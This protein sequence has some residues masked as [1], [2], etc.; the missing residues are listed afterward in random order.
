MTVLYT[1]RSDWSLF[2]CYFQL[3]NG[4]NL[5]S[6]A[7]RKKF[8]C[9]RLGCQLGSSKSAI[10][11]KD[12]NAQEW[13]EQFPEAV[14]AIHMEHYTDDHTGNADTVEKGGK[15][16]NEVIKIHMAGGFKI[17]K[18]VSNSTEFLKLIPEELRATGSNFDN[19]AELPVERVLGLWWDAK[20]DVFT[21]K[22]NF[23]KVD[24]TILDGSRIPTKRQMASLVMSLYDPL[25]FVA[26]FKV[27]GMMLLQEAWK[28]K[29]SWDDKIPESLYQ[30]SV[31][32]VEELKTIVTTQIPRCYSHGF[33]TAKNVQ[34]HIF[35]DA[36]EKAF[37]AVSYLR[38]ET[39]TQVE[40]SIMDGKVRVAPLKKLTVPRLELQAALMGS[41][42][43]ETIKNSLDLKIDNVQFWSNSK[44]VLCWLRAKKINVK[45]FVAFQIG[46][47]LETNE[48]FCWRWIPTA[49]VADDATRENKPSDFSE[50][51]RWFNGP[52]FL[53][54]P[55]EN[56]PQENRKETE[57]GVTEADL[58]LCHVI[59]TIIIAEESLLPDISRFLSWTRLIRATVMKTKLAKVWQQKVIPGTHV[60]LPSEPGTR[61]QVTADEMKQAE[62]LWWRMVQV[63]SFSSEIRSIQKEKPLDRESRLRQLSP[64]L[65]EEGFPR[66]K[67]RI[68]A[69]LDLPV[70][71]KRPIILNPNHS[72]TKLL[73]DHCH[74]EGAHQGQARVMN[75]LRQKF[76]ILDIR[77]AVRASWTRCQECKNK[78]AQPI[79]PEMGALPSSRVTIR[80]LVKPELTTLV[81]WK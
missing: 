59:A 17:D 57:E 47:I 41:R 44:T 70:E 81:P 3:E 78:R 38:V 25:G 53:K 16:A 19:K 60:P 67:G 52:A 13:N 61:P 42:M 8:P 51:S 79:L 73:I 15:L 74:R 9:A 64:L 34:L 46:E 22:T 63:D 29:T 50:E 5:K 71:T 11:V 21:F 66:V 12:K 14:K 31:P 77:T 30:R 80:R 20:T 7:D 56:W 76:C 10:Y 62:K 39:G 69:A 1:F 28:S 54:P 65:N 75:D 35:V 58:E 4:Q 33:S 55:P 45:Q 32:W 6:Q 24:Q 23:H 27:K 26:H 72:Y 68:D 36:S 48:A 40:V 43:S 49:L 2:I 37:A 18:L